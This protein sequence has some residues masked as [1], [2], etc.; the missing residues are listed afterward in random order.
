MLFSAPQLLFAAFNTDGVGAA[1]TV[2][3]VEAAGPLTAPPPAPPF[4]HPT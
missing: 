2:E 4:V 1:E 3:A